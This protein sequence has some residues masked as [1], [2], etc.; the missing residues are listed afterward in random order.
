[1]AETIEPIVNA[2]NR[3]FWTA[4]EEGRLV[5][6]VCLQTGRAFWPPSP[7]SP[8]VTGGE[9]RWREAVPAGV[10]QALAVYRRAFQKPFEAVMPYGVGLVELADGPR[11]QVHVADPDSATA[12]AVGDPVRIAF[13]PVLPGGPKVLHAQRA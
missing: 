3:P 4:A 13:A 11:L 2:L 6:P 1:M 9:T 5:L 10:M 12:P 7:F 8:F